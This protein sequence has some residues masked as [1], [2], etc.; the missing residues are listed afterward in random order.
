MDKDKI[1]VSVGI[2]TI[3]VPERI[4]D[5][6]FDRMIE[7]RKLVADRY[8]AAACGTP[9]IM[10]GLR[11]GSKN[12]A[13]AEAT[14]SPAATALTSVITPPATVAAVPSILMGTLPP[15]AGV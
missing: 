13:Q 7:D 14:V 8:L 9:P 5:K 12:W 15:N 6:V 4:T 10:I 11:E 1:I 3:N 2:N